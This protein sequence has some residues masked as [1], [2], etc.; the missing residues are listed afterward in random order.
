[1]S[2]GFK[3]YTTYLALKRH[4]TSDY[5]YFKYNGKVNA[6][7]A[8]FMKRR[9][10]YQFERLERKHKDDIEDFLVANFMK[11]PNVWIGNLSEGAYIEW[12][13]MKRGMTYNFKQD[14]LKLADY[15]NEKEL[16]FND[17]FKARSN[18]HPILLKMTMTDF[19]SIYSMCVLNILTNYL[20]YWERKYEVD[21]VVQE[22]VDKIRNYLGFMSINRKEYVSLLQQNLLTNI[23][24][25]DII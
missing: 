19:V 24:E 6:S 23:L 9:D 1:M 21:P 2:T 17:L 25:H 5:N 8:S 15:L 18:E 3:A 11:D 13:K 16:T 12:N 10:R 4:F 14:C 20:D 22:T 7:E